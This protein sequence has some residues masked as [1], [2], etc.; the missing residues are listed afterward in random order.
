M[1]R[2][3]WET[4]DFQAELFNTVDFDPFLE[5]TVASGLGTD[6]LVLLPPM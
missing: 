6:T 4:L 1:T 5:S 3:E 2:R